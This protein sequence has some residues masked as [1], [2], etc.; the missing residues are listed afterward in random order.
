MV[1]V[2]ASLQGELP[3]QLTFGGRLLFAP[4]VRF[5]GGRVRVAISGMRHS[6]RLCHGPQRR[7]RHCAQAVAFRAGTR[8]S[9]AA[10]PMGSLRAAVPV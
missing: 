3:C 8:L 7:L 4:L 1:V 9:G 6:R 2:S 10:T 5:F